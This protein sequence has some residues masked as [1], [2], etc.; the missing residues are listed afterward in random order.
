MS[1][2]LFWFVVAFA[3]VVEGQYDP[4]ANMCARW[5]DQSVIKG[6]KLYIDGE[7]CRAT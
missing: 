4:I 3:L 5:D 1:Y 2:F 6:S 7:W